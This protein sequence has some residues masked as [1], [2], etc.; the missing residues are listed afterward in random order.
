VR[1]L[2]GSPAEIYERHTVQ[3]FGLMGARDLLDLVPPAVGERVSWNLVDDPIPVADRLHRHRRSPLTPSKKLPQ[4][5]GLSP[6][7]LGMHPLG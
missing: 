3:H 5:A 2:N 1:D 6:A 4:C 7:T